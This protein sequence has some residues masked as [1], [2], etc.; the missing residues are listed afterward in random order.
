MTTVDVAE[1]ADRP[2]GPEC[3][4][5]GAPRPRH[6]VAFAPVNGER[7]EPLFVS[8]RTVRILQLSDGTRTVLEI[9][10]EIGSGR[11]RAGHARALR[12]IEELFQS[13]LLWL[14]ER[15]LDRIEAAWP[16][17]VHAR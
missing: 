2:T 4:D 8:D 12:Q 11:K 17:A 15:Q 9:A 10:R 7:R 1:L 6:V 13:G 5:A 3:A 16:A 14:R